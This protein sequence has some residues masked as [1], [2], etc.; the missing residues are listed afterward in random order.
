[1]G[2]SISSLTKSSCG[3]VTGLTDRWRAR[4]GAA[5]APGG[6]AAAPGTTP[7]APGSG[8]DAPGAA[9]PPLPLGPLPRPVSA[10]GSMKSAP[11]AAIPEAATSAGGARERLSPP[12]RR[13]TAGPSSASRSA[14]ATTEGAE[15]GSSGTPSSARRGTSARPRIWSGQGTEPPPKTLTQEDAEWKPSME[16]SEA[17]RIGTVGTSSQISLGSFEPDLSRLSQ[18]QRAQLVAMDQSIHDINNEIHSLLKSNPHAMNTRSHW[19]AAVSVRR[20]LAANAR[21]RWEEEVHDARNEGRAPSEKLRKEAAE[22]AKRH[23]AAVDALVG[24]QQSYPLKNLEELQQEL[25]SLHVQRQQLLELA[26][27]SPERDSPPAPEP[28]QPTAG[29]EPAAPEPKG[30]EAVRD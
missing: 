9:E 6:T 24:V 17:S 10:S 22:S 21:A 27:R 26:A 18:Q 11:R 23:R 7:A 12:A 14:P 28:E 30:K 16:G 20:P 13:D 1:M 2:N 5:G 25:D 19:E 4:T 15:A 29:D 3:L 8:T